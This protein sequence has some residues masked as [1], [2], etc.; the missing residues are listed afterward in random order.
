MKNYVLT[1]TG[2]LLFSIISIFMTTAVN[3]FKNEQKR[4]KRV[5][6]AYSVKEQYLLNLLK[7]KGI[8]GFN[9]DL[10]FRAFK[11]EQ[12]FEVW[13]RE[14]TK[15]KYVLLKTYKFCE[16]SGELGPKRKQGDYQIPEGFYHVDRFN[17]VS[18]YHLSLGIN[19]PN[20]SDRILGY[21][22][23]L[24]GDIFIHGD[25]VTIGCIPLSDDKI[26]EVY[27]LA[28][29]AKN[30]NGR[31][32]V[33]IFPAKFKN[34]AIE[35]LDNSSKHAKF[36]ENIKKG[37]ELFEKNKTLFNVSVNSSGEYVFSE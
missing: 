22:S 18:N 9:N 3:D 25:C 4:Y 30:K 8:D 21:K 7:E 14:K 5:R 37:Y 28:V 20:K 15:S 11:Q 24:G 33:N 2:L 17:P 36:W 35:S 16:I 31:I 10:F 19:Y 26:K 1:I 13:V 29:E 27:I 6:D 23:R 12:E 32:P 34:H